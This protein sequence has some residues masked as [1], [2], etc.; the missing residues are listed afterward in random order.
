MKYNIEN[1]RYV[2]LKVYIYDHFLIKYP[3]PKN[4]K[5]NKKKYVNIIPIRCLYVYSSPTI[6]RIYNSTIG[7]SYKTNIKEV[8]RSLRIK[9]IKTTL[10]VNVQA[11]PGLLSMRLKVF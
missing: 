4:K 2:Y 9:M 11:F 3:P 10:F 8:F 7:H 5:E 1:F 6:F